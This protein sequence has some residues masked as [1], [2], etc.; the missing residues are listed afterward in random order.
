MA[1]GSIIRAE[2]LDAD[3]PALIEVAV[4]GDRNA[5]PPL[6]ARSV[7]NTDAQMGNSRT[8]AV[9]WIAPRTGVYY[10][11]VSHADNERSADFTYTASFT[12]VQLQVAELGQDQVVPLA[13]PGHSGWFAREVTPG[14]TLFTTLTSSGDETADPALRI[15]FSYRTE[16]GQDVY[17]AQIRFGSDIYVFNN[18][19]GYLRYFGGAGVTWPGSLPNSLLYYR[20]SDATMRGGPG[21]Q[22]TF[23]GGVR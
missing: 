16:D 5:D 6:P 18:T 1:G 3:F 11:T 15:Y 10:M 22:L 21:Y 14:Q 12:Q 7:V 13:R 2:I 23:N 19:N 4:L 20:V 9:E 17:G 8:N